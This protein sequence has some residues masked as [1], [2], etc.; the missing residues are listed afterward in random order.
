MIRQRKNTSGPG[1]AK[2]QNQTPK[3]QS[4]NPIQDKT[5]DLDDKNE[6]A[7]TKVCERPPR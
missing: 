6:K 3:S 7:K 2:N 4:Q 1:Q 5:D